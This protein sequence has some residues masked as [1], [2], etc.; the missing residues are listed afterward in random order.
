M[1]PQ[2]ICPADDELARMVAGK[3][4]T[5]RVDA[6]CLHVES[7]T[8]CQGLLTQ[9]EVEPDGFI[10]S[11]TSITET[12]LAKAR[13]EMELE[14]KIESERMHDY[15]TRLPEPKSN[16]PT[17][18]PPCQLGPY[19]VQK[20]IAKGGMGEVYEAKHLRLNRPVALK[21]I[22]GYR[23]EDPASE[24]YFLRE[25]ANAGKLDHPNLVRAYDAWEADGCLYM[26]FELLDGQS[27]QNHFAKRNSSTL[28][29]ALDAILGTCR[30][31]EYLHNQGLV[32]C[33]IK[34]SNV[35]RLSDG[36]IKLIDFGLAID[37]ALPHSPNG[38]GTKGYM[39]PE[40]KVG[41][42]L[43][44]QRVDIY[45]LGCLLK[46]MLTGCLDSSSQG[47]KSAE[48]KEL[49]II[50]ERMT[51]D[52]PEQRYQSVKEV[53]ILLENLQKKA[54][55]KGIISWKTLIVLA[56]MGFLVACISQISKPWGFKSEE[57]EYARALALK[58]LRQGFKSP[59]PMQMVTIPA[60]DFVMG[61]C[62]GDSETLADELPCRTITFTKPFQMGIYE[63]TVAQF[64]EFV[65]AQGHKTQAE[66]SG[67]GGWKA[68]TASSWG[69]QH[70]DLNWSSPGYPIAADLPVTMVSYEDALA[71]CEWL[72]RRDGKNYRLPTEAEWEYACRA[73]STD[74]YPFPFKS[75]DSYCW[76]IWNT[77]KTV[78]P[79]PVGT[80]QSNPWGLFDM[81]G[82]AREWCLD[83][84]GEKAY[85]LSQKEFP[86]GPVNGTL[87]VI[88]G[89][90]FID[91]NSFLRSSRRGYLAP[92]QVL[93]NQG[94][95]VVAEGN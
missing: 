32:H 65:E 29:D 64:L 6:I 34:P 46:F 18:N 53:R 58:D 30:A 94:F 7:C 54:R 17:L 95:R 21:V 35:I 81:G 51:M 73:G 20:L 56:A 1:I 27:L 76:S 91:M 10:R 89:G 4:P 57:K 69:I 12:A 62:D 9:L 68:S 59:V 11:L 71:F 25:M 87:R 74:V 15:L 44:D 26:A 22:R 93:N 16:R 31:L 43:I 8:K 82:N 42:G 37:M 19:E 90:C 33:D 83:W 14:S 36:S 13:T 47:A 75:R 41:G 38:N 79:R 72:S 67:F 23:Q 66:S 24:G 84:Y 92:D 61:A 28:V 78:C 5:D 52:A 70:P 50:A 80:R 77:K 48:A 40:Q 49:I 2:S 55:I 85:L 3:L 86:Q 63:V 39:A 88:R 60:G 45:S